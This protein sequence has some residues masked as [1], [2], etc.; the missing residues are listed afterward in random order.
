[1]DEFHGCFWHGCPTCHPV[2]NEEH[3]RLHQR[4]VHDVYQTT[5]E[6]MPRL[7]VKGNTVEGMCECEWKRQKDAH[8]DIQLYVDSPQF[9]EPLNPRDAFCGRR[10]NAIKLLHRVKPDQKFHFIEYTSLYPWVNKTCVYTEGRPQFISQPDHTDID[11]YFGFVQW[12]VL[13][14]VNSP[15]P[16]PLTVKWVNSPFLSAPPVC[17]TKRTNPP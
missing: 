12:Q 6:K 2:R 7:R 15:I 10:T 3:L 8:P 17:K 9:L 5:Q 4:T 16:C 11:P 13:P 1:M 14:R